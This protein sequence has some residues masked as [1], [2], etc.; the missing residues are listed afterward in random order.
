MTD[1]T[2][3]RHAALLRA[4]DESGG[5]LDAASAAYYAAADAEAAPAAA[6]P[7]E[8][9]QSTE[10][11]GAISNPYHKPGD[12][13]PAAL[14]RLS[15]G[16]LDELEAT[17]PGICDRAINAADWDSRR[18]VAAERDEREATRLAQVD[19]IATDPERHFLA[20]D[21]ARFRQ[22]YW[23]LSPGQRRTEAE[24]IGI[25]L[26]TYEPPDNAFGQT[27]KEPSR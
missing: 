10:A 19:A 13:S 3:P 1:T 14:A 12:P 8:P 22:T 5:D 17:D 20:T 2:N 9:P 6:P 26:D 21:V 27:Y 25:D 11:E 16:E 18:A 23:Q 4:W 7:P 24:R 15:S